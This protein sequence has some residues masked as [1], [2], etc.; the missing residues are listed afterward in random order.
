MSYHTGNTAVVK[1]LQ[2]ALED[3]LAD[4]RKSAMENEPGWAEEWKKKSDDEKKELSG[5]GC[6]DCTIAGQLLGSIY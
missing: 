3:F 6:E 5:C 2:K 4:Q 1:A